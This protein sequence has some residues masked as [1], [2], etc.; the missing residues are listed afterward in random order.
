MRTGFELVEE[1]EADYFGT[2]ACD[3]SNAT[4]EIMIPA[5]VDNEKTG[6]YARLA[7]FRS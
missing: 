4:I 1:E 6:A 3:S 5:M 7:P 2:V